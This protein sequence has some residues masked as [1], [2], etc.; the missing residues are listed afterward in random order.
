MRRALTSIICFS[1]LTVVHIARAQ[2]Y[3]PLEVGNRWDFIGS[4]YDTQTH[5][6]E[7]DTMMLR[8]VDFGR[9]ANGKDYYELENRGRH[10][11]SFGLC[12]E[13]F[14]RV[15]SMRMYVYFEEDSTEEVY[16]RFDAGQDE[17]WPLS[18]G[19]P[20]TIQLQSIDSTE[21]FQ[22]PTR[23]LTYRRDGLILDWI[24][25]SERF[26]P[27]ARHSEGEPPGTRRDDV[28]LVGC[29]LSGVTY[30]QLLVDVEQLH[31]PPA[32]DVLLPAY[33]NPFRHA[34][35]VP[36]AMKNP[37]TVMITIVNTLGSVILRRTLEATA[38]SNQF[39]W[40]PVGLPPVV[41]LLT[42]NGREVRRTAKLVITE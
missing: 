29:I 1:L 30:G 34:T 25:L 3:V 2:Q 33:P 9:Q 37:G 28:T 11:Y 35:T 22:L 27:L 23:I 8:I 36:F 32:A 24:T 12:M 14:I 41:Y 5:E 20:S 19:W 17:S 40:R 18:H 6:S 13:R 21:V 4:Y 26:G 15:D 16:Y 31:N 7:R 38:G 39:R 42:L 10:G